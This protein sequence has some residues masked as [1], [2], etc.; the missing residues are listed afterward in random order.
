MSTLSGVRHTVRSTAARTRRTLLWTPERYRASIATA[1]AL[2]VLVPLVSLVV[3]QPWNAPA[4]AD[5]GTAT[6]AGADGGLPG[7][8]VNGLP[9]APAGAGQGTA[10]ASTGATPL[11]PLP[12]ATGATPTAPVDGEAV[13]GATQGPVDASAISVAAVLAVAAEATPLPSRSAGGGDATLSPGAATDRWRAQ[14][15][16]TSARF[17]QKWLDGA[18]A[19]RVDTWVKGLDPWLDP[20]S[21]DLVALTNLAQIPRT[22]PTS[23]QLVT[24]EESEATSVVTLADGGR[25][26]LEL[27]WDG[28][29]WR[30]TSYEPVAAAG[31]A[32]PTPAGGTGTSPAGA[33]GAP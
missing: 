10:P 26:D 31:V 7:G 27:V 25:L 13:P 20:G 2:L 14:A 29:T 19:D 6:R 33:S 30:V 9:A 12:D 11:V 21:R 17:T 3:R 23:V 15:R 32:A 18:T 24:L 1:V 22:R 28:E 5:Q 16:T 4:T 8:V